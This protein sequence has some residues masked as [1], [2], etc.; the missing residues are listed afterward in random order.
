MAFTSSRDVAFRG[1]PPAC[2]SGISGA[3]SSHCASV[4][5]VS[6]RRLAGGFLFAIGRRLESLVRRP[7]NHAKAPLGILL[8]RTLSP[9]ITIL[10]SLGQKSSM[11]NAAIPVRR[12][13]KM[14]WLSRGL[15][16]SV[17]LRARG[18]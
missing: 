13:L 9:Q 10:C 11:L 16:H 17:P 1:L 7:M 4:R 8:K 3:S 14:R 5:S 15:D 6:Y 2:A 18:C 12:L